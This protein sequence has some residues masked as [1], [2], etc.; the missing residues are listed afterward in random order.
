MQSILT[1]I[2]RDTLQQLIDNKVFENKELEYKSY[3]FE[4][5]KLEEKDKTALIQEIIAFANASGGIIILGIREN[6]NRL[7]IQL[8]GAGLTLQEY[9]NWLSSLRQAILSRIRPHLHG[10]EYKPVELDDG[11]IAIVIAVPRSYSR[12]HSFWD[13]NKDTF[14]IRYAN[15][16]SYMDIDD[17]RKQFLFG[18][19]IQSQIKQ[20]RADR[21]SMIL[22]NECVGDLGNNAKFLFHIIPE[23]SFELGNRISMRGLYNSLAEDLIPL[24]GSAWDDRYNS[25]GYCL[26]AKDHQTGRINT[27]TQLFHNGIIE[28]VEVKLFSSYREKQVFNWEQTQNDIIKATYRYS[29]ALMKLSIPKPW[30]LFATILNA[31]D[32]FTTAGKWGDSSKTLERDIIHSLDSVWNDDDAIDAVLKPILDSLSNAFGFSSSS[33]FDQTGKIKEAYKK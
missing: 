28:A 32:Y 26:F 2:S 10:V 18:G 22:A 17:L 8:V 31:K 13:G 15:G 21:I 25:D 16:K 20:F 3:M 27:Y 9:D 23:W 6:E 24:S 30:H 5:G 11:T 1:N 29:D 33:I 7:P 19:T 4:N 12:P 14:Y